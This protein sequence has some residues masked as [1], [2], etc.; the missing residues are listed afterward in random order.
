MQHQGVQKIS[1]SRWLF[2]QMLQVIKLVWLFVLGGLLQAVW[3]KKFAWRAFFL[4]LI[5][6]VS[7]IAFLGHTFLSQNVE[8]PPNQ[9]LVFW[10]LCGLV[11][12]LSGFVLGKYSAR[13]GF[14]ESYALS[15]T[16]FFIFGLHLAIGWPK[17]MGLPPGGGIGLCG[18]RL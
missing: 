2:L 9:M 11:T 1:L 17:L 3:R 4:S 5:L 13:L 10:C 14:W 12:L 7:L 8:T 16:T 15:A 6:Q 18:S